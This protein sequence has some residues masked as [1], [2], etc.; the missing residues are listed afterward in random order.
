M[1]SKIRWA[2]M[3]SS[4]SNT[5]PPTLAR[6]GSCSR[7]WASRPIYDVDFVPDVPPPHVGA[8][9]SNID[10]NT[11]NVHQSRMDH[12]VQFYERLFGFTEIRY[13]DIHGEKTGLRSRALVSPCGKIRI[14][15]N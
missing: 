8:G 2:R 3:D 15:I 7:P 10:H 6:S 9:L 1:R 11:H 12:W 4:S 13:F 14:P 5:R